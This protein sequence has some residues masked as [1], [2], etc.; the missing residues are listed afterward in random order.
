MEFGARLMGVPP[1]EFTGARDSLARELRREGR[2]EEAAEVA[3][4]RRP[5]PALWAVN[6]LPSAAPDLLTELLEAATALREGT[7]A[8]LLGRRGGLAKLSA[9]HGRL[10]DALTT[11]AM[12]VLASA[13]RSASAETRLRIWTIVRSASSAP[14]A[15]ASLAEGALL[16]EP[17]NVGFD[18]LGG[19]ALGEPGEEEAAAA[20][21]PQ[22]DLAELRAQRE[23]KRL[24][25]EAVN[26]LEAASRRAEETRIDLD[27]AREHVADAKAALAGAER[28]LRKAT[29]DAE[30]AG[31]ALE[32]ARQEL[33][34]LDDPG[35]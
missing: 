22:D 34:G 35:D 15:S 30:K 12:V 6:Q 29:A 19:F 23:R 8:A 24:R 18:G 1:E 13:G 16:T 20:V 4:V 3:K 14:E 28:R 2:G 7:Q 31:R 27:D 9:T 5:S 32:A 21:I 26:T 25:R 33:D 11:Q 10:V 17:A